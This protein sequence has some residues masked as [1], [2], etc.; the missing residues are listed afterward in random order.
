[1]QNSLKSTKFKRLYFIKNFLMIWEHPY[2]NMLR[3]KQQGVKLYIVYDHHY[4]N[5]LKARGGSGGSI[6][7]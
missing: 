7:R 6:C 5:Y 1:M 2:A 4:V 3:K